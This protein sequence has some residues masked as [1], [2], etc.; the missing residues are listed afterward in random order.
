M[1]VLGGVQRGGDPVCT[2]SSDF[3]SPWRRTWKHT[4]DQDD[5]VGARF[6]DPVVRGNCSDIA[7]SGQA[8]RRERKAGKKPSDLF[9]TKEDLIGPEPSEALTKYVAWGRL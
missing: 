6:V 8:T 7:D 3:G 4:G 9:L 1:A 5:R 2:E